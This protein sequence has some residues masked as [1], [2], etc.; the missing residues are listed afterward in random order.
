M[1]IP[2]VF[3]GADGQSHFDE[4]DIEIQVGESAAASRLVAGP[5]VMF[6]ETGGDYSLDFHPAPRRQFIVNLDGW[7]ELE[8]GDGTS[9]RFGPG[10]IFLANGMAKPRLPGCLGLSLGIRSKSRTWRARANLKSRRSLASREKRWRRL[11]PRSP[12]RRILVKLRHEPAPMVP[13]AFES[14]LDASFLMGA[15]VAFWVI[16]GTKPPPWIMKVGMTRWKIVPS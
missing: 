13:R 15:S 1:K 5:G 11:F 8:V 14:P 12:P 9:R 4:I 10:S 16:P 6:R 2:R 3:T 7:V